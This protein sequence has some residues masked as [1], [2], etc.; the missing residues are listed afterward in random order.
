VFCVHGGLSPNLHT[1]DQVR[2]LSFRLSQ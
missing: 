2:S 1:I